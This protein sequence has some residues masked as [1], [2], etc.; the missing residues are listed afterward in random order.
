LYEESWPTFEEGTKK[1]PTPRTLG[2]L[3]FEKKK[4]TFD[5]SVFITPNKAEK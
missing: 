1:V 3:A 4:S 2:I 5:F